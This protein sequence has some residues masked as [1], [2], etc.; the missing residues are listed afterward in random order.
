[1]EGVALDYFNND[2]IV[3]YVNSSYAFYLY[4]GEDNTQDAP[5]TH[6]HIMNI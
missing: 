6:T 3:I 1:M 5:G 2:N 4:L